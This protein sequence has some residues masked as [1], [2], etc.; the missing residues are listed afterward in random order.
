MVIAGDED[1]ASSARPKLYSGILQRAK[2]ILQLFLLIK[3]TSF[4][5]VQVSF[6]S[7]QQTDKRSEFKRFPT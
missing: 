3:A 2:R 7:F 5:I 4:L 6:F 1:T